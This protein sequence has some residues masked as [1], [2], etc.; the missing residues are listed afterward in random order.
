MA[1]DPSTPQPKLIYRYTIYTNSNKQLFQVVYTFLTNLK[2]TLHIHSPQMNFSSYINQH[3]TSS[4]VG[5]KP[6]THTRIGDRKAA[7]PGGNFHFDDNDTAILHT[8]YNTHMFD[9]SSIEPKSNEYL[10]EKQSVEDGPIMI[11]LDFRYTTEVDS[12]QHTSD[13]ISDFVDICTNELRKMMDEAELINPIS[14]NIFVMEK[15]DVRIEEDKTKDGVHILI[16]LSC[17]KAVQLLLREKII[18]EISN[19]WDDLPITNSWS[20]V[21]DEGVIKGHANWQM[22]GSRKP[23]Q[24]QYDPYLVTG[25]YKATFNSSGYELVDE[26][27]DTNPLWKTLS[28]NPMPTMSA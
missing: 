16:S 13:H 22:Y 8:K 20:D 10:T 18:P 24:K 11:D 17:H 6:S 25:I 26:S 2:P 21:V 3:R 28:T 4:G 5:N 1:C 19:T 15:P 12:R 14:V 9:G 7:I 27:S 23:G